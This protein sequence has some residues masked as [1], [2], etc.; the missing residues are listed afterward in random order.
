[1]G[2]SPVLLW[3][4]PF[5]Y[6]PTGPEIQGDLTSKSTLCLFLSPT[7]VPST[8]ISPGPVQ[9]P[10]RRLHSIFSAYCQTNFSKTTPFIQQQIFE[11]LLF[12]RTEVHQ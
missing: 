12:A 7:V 2:C 5:L 6:Q 4:R 8:M 9:Q 1:M 10:P 11:Y 3:P